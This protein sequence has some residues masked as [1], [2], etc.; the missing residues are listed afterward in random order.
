[1]EEVTT[2]WALKEHII[3]PEID[4]DKIDKIKGIGHMYYYKRK[5]Q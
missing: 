2:H 3:F 4:F 1:M 5:E